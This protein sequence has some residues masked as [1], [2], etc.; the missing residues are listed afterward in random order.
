MELETLRDFINQVEEHKRSTE[1]TIMKCENA[2]RYLELK[3]HYDTLSLISRDLE[4]LFI[5]ESNK[6]LEKD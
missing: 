6:E 4:T 3:A 5:E 2:L 1:K